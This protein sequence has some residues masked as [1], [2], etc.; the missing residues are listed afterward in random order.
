M[1][2][3]IADAIATVRQEHVDAVN[4]RDV[5]L[6]L[7]GMTNDVVYLFPGME[8]LIGKDALRAYVTPIYEQ[9]SIDIEMRHESLDI[10]GSRAVEWGV[11]RGQMTPGAQST[12]SLVNL[13]YIFVYRLEP[14][15]AWRISHA[16]ASARPVE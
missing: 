15:G 6:L 7:R 10:A 13:K 12:P 2:E 4:G 3:E 5:E 14:D 1:D 16:I 11:V 8:P 9:A